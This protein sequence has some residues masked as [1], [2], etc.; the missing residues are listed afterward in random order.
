MGGVGAMWNVAELLEKVISG[1]VP[2]DFVETG[3]WKGA[4]GILAR[5]IL[6]AAGDRKRTVWCLDS[7]EWLPPPS[8]KYKAD[9]GDA[10]HTYAKANPVLRADLPVV[11]GIYRRFGIDVHDASQRVNLVKGF[12]NVT[13][14]VVARQVADI[15]ILRLDGDMYQSTWEVHRAVREGV[16]RR[17]CDRRRLRTRR[18]SPRNRRVSRVRGH[19]LALGGV[20]RGVPRGHAHLRPPGQSL[21]G[22]DGGG[23]A[24]RA[25]AAV[26]R[27]QVQ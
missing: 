27:A 10:N 23:D 19:R 8:A 21:L 26:L 14:P 20:P 24:R 5:K 25:R 18:L 16:R 11:E 4:N 17:F 9:R 22:Q 7:F 12:F 2:G 3:V 15:S 6:D 1:P 13:A